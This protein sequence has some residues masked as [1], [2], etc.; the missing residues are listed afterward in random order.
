[1]QRVCPFELVTMAKPIP[2]LTS[3]EV[4]LIVST[5]WEDKVP[6]HQ[7][8]MQHGLS[9]GQ[10]VPLMKRELTPSAFKLWKQRSGIR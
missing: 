9:Q 3:D 8:L 2:R 5:A 6:F 1:M 7:V 10:L 4:S